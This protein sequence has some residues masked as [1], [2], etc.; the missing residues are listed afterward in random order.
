MIKIIKILRA[1]RM[2]RLLPERYDLN[3]PL[4]CIYIYTLYFV[5]YPLVIY[6]C[7]V[8][9]TVDMLTL[10]QGLPKWLWRK[11]SWSIHNI[12]DIMQEDICPWQSPMDIYS[13]VEVLSVSWRA[14]QGRKKQSIEVLWVPICN[15]LVPLFLF[16]FHRFQCS[17]HAKFA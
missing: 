10:L 15:F 17:I 3:R 14:R 6:M 16:P 9:S 7:P 1:R 8:C 2:I 11:H 12:E 5:F 4:V 13:I